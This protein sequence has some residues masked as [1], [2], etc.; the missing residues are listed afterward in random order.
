MSGSRHSP[1]D[2]FGFKLFSMS[3]VF[4]F[5]HGIFPSQV[6]PRAF[7]FIRS[8]APL[9]HNTSVGSVRFLVLPVPTEEFS[10]PYS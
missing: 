9:A 5:C 4:V 6:E 10:F 7:F 2:S 8:G 3:K 1:E